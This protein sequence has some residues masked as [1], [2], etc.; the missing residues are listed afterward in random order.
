LLPLLVGAALPETPVPA[1]IVFNRDVR[2]ILSENCFACHGPDAAHLKGKLRLDVRE[3]ALSREAFVP[4]QP[5]ESTLVE[6]IRSRDEDE[7]M[8]P[9]DSHK[10]L[11]ERDRRVLERW[12]EQGATYQKHWSYE[13]PVKAAIPP[14]ENAID[15]LVRR[16]LTEVGLRPAP[17]ADRRTQLRRLHADLTG[18]PPTP[19]EM[20]AFVSDHSPDAYGRAVERLLANPH[21][22]ERMAIGWLDVVRYADTIGYHSD[23]PRNVWPYRDWVIASFNANQRFDRFTLEQIAGDLLPDANQSTRV[24]SAFNR[25]LLSTEEGGAQPKDYESRMLAD[26]VRAIGAAWL[27][28][29][30]GCA[31]CHDHK[32]DPFT[33]RDFYSLGAFFADV[34]EDA[35]GR[36]ED[37]MLVLSAEERTQLAALDATVKSAQ[38]KVTAVEPQLQAA[39]ST[40]LTEVAAT[41]NVTSVPREISVVLRKEPAR[42]TARERQ[43][44]RAHFRAHVAVAFRA[45]LDAL[46]NAEAARTTWLADRARCLVTE[47]MAER[48]VV[49]ILPRGN[50]LDETGEM[51]RPALPHYLPQPNFG[52]RVPDR[53][54]LAR[55]LVSRENPLTARTV[56]NRLWKQF[57]G[58]GLSRVADDLGRRAK[59]PQRR[60]ARLAGVR[61]HGQRL[62]S[63]A[64][65]SLDRHQRDLSAVFRRCARVAGE[66]S[67]QPRACAAEPLPF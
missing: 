55:W 54:D 62:G 32:F 47:S 60:A 23:N 64:H 5:R 52:D 53:L 28:Q 33:A 16:R 4:G 10:T 38:G 2:P 37:G 42:R 36:R 25:L 24:G 40:W 43:T 61:V 18:L 8:P 13:A 34:K 63:E 12:I 45:E 7:V 27:G 6:R 67:R 21:Y 50:W 48:R 65:G 49:R 9:P 26:R 30:T 56:M 58:V 17:E 39:E 31:Q 15:V 29:T 44:L 51:V 57:F 14:G 59:R 35:I 22:G 41:A 46:A 11:T 66:R 1:Q 3:A 19:E 20:G